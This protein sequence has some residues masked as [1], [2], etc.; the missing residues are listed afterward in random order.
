MAENTKNEK[1]RMGLCLKIVLTFCTLLFTIIL[2]LALVSISSLRSSA[3]ETTSFMAISKA[4]GALS[5]FEYR[6]TSVHGRLSLADSTLVGETED[7]SI[8]GDHVFI[9]TISQELNAT[10]TILVRQ[11][12]DF[13]R[14]L[15]SLTDDTGRRQD[16]TLLGASHPAISS[17]LNGAV[18]FEPIILFGK[19]YFTGYKPIFAQGT[20]EVIGALAI[21]IPMET[22]DTYL[23]NALR[24]KIITFIVLSLVLLLAAIFFIRLVLR[25]II[26]KPLSEVLENL[27]W[28]AKG[29]FTHPLKPRGNDEITD[30]VR[31]I[32]KTESSINSLIRGIKSN[33]QTLEEFAGDLTSNMHETATA[34]DEIE[35]QISSIKTRML[36]QSASVNETH[37]TMAQITGNIN[38]LNNLIEQ[39]ASSVDQGSA[40]MEEM[41]ANIN[42]VTQ[43]L[44]KNS[45]NVGELTSSSDAGRNSLEE[46]IQDIQVIAKESEGLSEINSVMQ[47]IASQTNLLSMNA[48]IEAAH[49]GDAGRGFAVVADEIRKLAENSSE[50]SKTINTVL[51]EMKSSID[52]IMQSAANV[53]EKFGS[54]DTNVKIVAEQEELIRCSMQ[55]QEQGSK[56]L[57]EAISF[58]HEITQKVKSS[59]H[60]MHQGANEIITEMD[61]LQKVTEEI[62][63][64]MSEMDIGTKSINN[65]VH[66]LDE[67][68][69][70]NSNLINDLGKELSQFVINE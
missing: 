66:H 34:M 20:R 19:H 14:V 47:N 37:A 69:K 62:T 23:E 36:N 51:K 38:N 7:R 67:L 2:V 61:S 8:A 41:V 30:M 11:N 58:V 59:S 13:F 15:T 6:I 68:G 54:I 24:Q 56:Q 45:A 52:K 21:F 16:N 5:S 12:Q 50:Q 18:F 64:G 39:Q 27:S 42:S 43:T 25:R 57:L 65:S 32:I 3:Y 48:A 53:T 1:T 33:G 9:D 49:A 60:E 46:V 22:V 26:F 40:A 4:D 31:A 55:E 44:I 70:K 28:L 35:A 29:N 17:L 10:A 63:N